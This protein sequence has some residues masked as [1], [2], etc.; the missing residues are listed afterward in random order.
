MSE[1]DDLRDVQYEGE[2]FRRRLADRDAERERI[3][4]AIQSWTEIAHRLDDG[5]R[6]VAVEGTE[7]QP[8]APFFTELRAMVFPHEEGDRGELAQAESW[9]AAAG[10]KP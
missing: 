10:E 8:L 6:P 2:G 3:W 1:E 9:D 5:G 7:F 4:T